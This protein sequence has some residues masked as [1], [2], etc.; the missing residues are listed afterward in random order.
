VNSVVGFGATWSFGSSFIS[1][2]LVTLANLLDPSEDRRSRVRILAIYILKAG[3]DFVTRRA[4][5]YKEF[6]DGA[7]F[8]FDIHC[9]FPV[10]D[11]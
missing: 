10:L 3:Y 11:V 1:K 6:D 8:V 5:Q 9:H 7:V 2:L 4:F